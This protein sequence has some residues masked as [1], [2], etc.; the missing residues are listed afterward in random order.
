MEKVTIEFYNFNPRIRVHHVINMES[1]P[2]V[3]DYIVLHKNAVKESSKTHR[4]GW[5]LKY[6]FKKVIVKTRT[7]VFKY[8]EKESI[9]EWVLRVEPV[10]DWIKEYAHRA[11]QKKINET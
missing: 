2:L 11:S 9:Q 7:K 10:G 5:A 1:V 4:I 6:G 8:Y 3:G